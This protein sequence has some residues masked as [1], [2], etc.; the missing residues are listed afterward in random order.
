M[1]ARR[2]TLDNTVLPVALRADG[3]AAD[4]A[5]HRAR[6]GLRERRSAWLPVSGAYDLGAAARVDA[7]VRRSFLA[8]LDPAVLG[9]LPR[10]LRR[11]GDRDAQHDHLRARGRLLE[12]PRRARRAARSSSASTPTATRCCR[13]SRASRSRSARSSPARSSSRS[14]SRIPASARSRSSA[15]QNRDY[16]LIQGIFLFLII[17]VL[18]ANL[19]IDIAYVFIDP[20]TRVGMQGGA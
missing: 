10:R 9:A 18:I 3:D 14:S 17:G 1:A 11:L 13:R 6:L 4:V 5:R 16:F 12:L 8:A 2:K 15:I 7:R 19:I 20:R